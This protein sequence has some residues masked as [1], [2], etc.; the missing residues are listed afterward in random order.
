MA[1]EELH[2]SLDAPEENEQRFTDKQKELLSLM[3]SYED[4]TYEPKS[5]DRVSGTLIAIKP[6]YAF[7]DIG[8]R[9]EAMIKTEEL[10][11]SEGKITK[12]IDD[13]VEGYVISVH[14]GEI[15]LSTSLSGYEA[16]MSQLYEAQKNR[17]PVLGKVTGVKKGGLNVSILGKRAFCPISKIDIKHTE[18]VNEYLG[19][20]GPFV[21]T[22]IKEKGRN[23]VVS[24]IPILEEKVGARLETLRQYAAEK[25]TISG[26]ITRITSFGLFVD[27]GDIEGLVHVSEVSWDKIDS[28]SQYF[29]KGQQVDCLV[30]SVEEKEPLRES[31]VSLSLKQ[32]HGD[33][34]IDAAR[35]YA[36]GTRVRGSVTQLKNFGAF[37]R[38]EPGVEGLVHV[39]EMSWTTR[40]RHPKD[41]VSVGDEVEAT[42]LSV[43]EQKR[44][45]ALSLKDREEDP[46]AEVPATFAPGTLATGHVEKEMPYGFFVNLQ[47][48]VT[49]LL[50]KANIADQD[51]QS[52]TQGAA[53]QVAIEAID[54]DNR[55][56]SLKSASLHTPADTGTASSQTR[57]PQEKK[58]KKDVTEFGSALRNALSGGSETRDE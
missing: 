53:V 41:V 58:G 13:Q 31:R 55:R 57:T 19:F 1:D 46:W 2:S 34:W 6:D 3:N 33:P 12:Q 20:N 43:D 7:I 48:G 35:R 25:K 39:S 47:Q 16:D 28:L 15:I 49:G 21:I 8:A 38:L 22:D 5:G 50:P 51:R 37:V 26:T 42:V 10:K 24:R 32:A 36:P 54:M 4:V 14:N 56:I 45:I 44:Q 30:L 9:N 29:Q 17:I 23:I 11:D 40:V 52:I 18:D 27:I